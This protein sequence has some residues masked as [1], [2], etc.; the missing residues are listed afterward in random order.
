M[1]KLMLSFIIGVLFLFIVFVTKK[2]LNGIR[3]E[4]F[5]QEIQINSD[6]NKVVE[7]LGEPKSKRLYNDSTMIYLYSV[8][9]FSSKI[10][11]VRFDQKSGKITKIYSSD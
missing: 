6:I 2:H 9:L 4:K 8:P 1:K 5:F 10:L 3:N 11:E 7:K